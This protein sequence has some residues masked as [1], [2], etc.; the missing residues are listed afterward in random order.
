MAVGKSQTEMQQEVRNYWRALEWIEEQ[1]EARRPVSEE[2]IR[3][4]HGII[5]VRGLGRRGLRSA[6]RTDE[7]PVCCLA[8]PLAQ[9]ELWRQRPKTRFRHKIW[10]LQ[11]ELAQVDPWALA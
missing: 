11:P 3:E 2:F 9:A 4:L 7:C 6:Y 5:L 10:F 1:I 8:Q